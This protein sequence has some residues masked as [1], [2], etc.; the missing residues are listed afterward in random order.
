MFHISIAKPGKKVK[1][2][3]FDGRVNVTKQN[4]DCCVFK[5]VLNIGRIMQKVK[6]KYHKNSSSIAR[7]ERRGYTFYNNEFLFSQRRI[8]SCFVPIAV[9]CSLTMPN[10]VRL[11]ANKSDLLRNNRLHRNRRNQTTL[12]LTRK[13]TH[14]PKHPMR[15][16]MRKTHKHRAAFKIPWRKHFHRHN[17]PA[18]R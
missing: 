12:L 9:I 10:S 5:I 3:R 11:A 17:R 6:E 7:Y 4:T 18:S 8:F 16:H 15:R 1:L 14:K 13:T 2:S